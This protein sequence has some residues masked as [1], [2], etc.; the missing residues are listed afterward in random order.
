MRNTEDATLP[1]GSHGSLLQG[2]II[3][4]VLLLVSGSIA[5]IARDTLSA[6][7]RR[8][9]NIAVYVPD[10]RPGDV[11]EFL[12]YVEQENRKLYAYFRV[13]AVTPDM[14]IGVHSVNEYEQS[15]RDALFQEPGFFAAEMSEIARAEIAGEFTAGTLND[16]RRLGDLAP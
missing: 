13:T 10:P 9:N 7:Q 8:Q 2:A 12:H 4:T 11:Y 6:D 14:L 1:S 16:I 15:Q 3:L 5:L